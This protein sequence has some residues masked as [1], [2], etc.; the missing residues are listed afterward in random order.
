MGTYYGSVHTIR[1]TASELPSLEFKYLE[2]G[3]AVSDIRCYYHRKLVAV[4]QGFVISDD[5]ENISATRVGEDYRSNLRVTMLHTQW[6]EFP[7]MHWARVWVNN[8]EAPPDEELPRPVL[9][10]PLPELQVSNGGQAKSFTLI[11]E[12]Y[13]PQSG[14][15]PPDCWS[16]G[17]YEAVVTAGPEPGLHEVA[18]G[19]VREVL[20]PQTPGACDF[21]VDPIVPEQWGTLIFSYPV[22]EFWGVELTIEQ[23]Q[24]SPAPVTPD[25]RLEEPLAVSYRLEPAEYRAETVE[26]DLFENGFWLASARGD[27]RSDTGIAHFG[28][29]LPMRLQSTYEAQVVINRGS[30]AEVRSDKIQV[31]VLQGII[32][33]LDASESYRGVD[34]TQGVFVSQE[35]DLLN[36]TSC[37]TGT[38]FIF[39]LAREARVTLTF[40][41]ID[42]LEPDGSTVR[43]RE[44]TLIDEELY[45][46]GEHHYLILPQDLPAGDYEFELRAVGTLDEQEEVLAGIGRSQYRVRNSLPVG[47]ALT[48]G[49]DLFDGHLSV[50]REDLAFPGRRPSLSLTRTYTSQHSDEP[51]VLGVGWIHSYHSRLIVT[52][53]G[54]VI[55]IGGDGSGMRFVDDGDG[56]LMPLKGYHGTLIANHED[57]TYDFYTKAGIR[58]HY[59]HTRNENEWYLDYIADPNGNLITLSYEG[60]YDEYRVEVVRDSAGRSLKFEYEERDFTFWSGKVLIQVQGPYGTSVSY[61]YDDFG[62]LIR[63]TREALRSERYGYLVP[64]DGELRDRHLLRWVEDEVTGASTNYTW[65]W[66]AIGLQ[67]DIEVDASYVASLTRSDSGTTS[68]AYDLS[69][70]SSRAPAELVTQ[71]KDSRN[72]ISVY[73]LNQYGSPLRIVDAEDNAT[74][75]EWAE[76]DVVMT[77][78]VDANGVRTEFTYDEHG[79]LVTESVTVTDMDGQEVTYLTQNTYASPSSFVPR[80]IKNRISERTD[81]NGHTTYFEYDERGNL[82]EERIEVGNV[83][84]A[85]LATLTLR[86]T[87]NDAGDRLSTED[88]RGNMTFFRYDVYG[89]VS[90]VTDARGGVTKTQWDVRSLPIRRTDALGRETVLEYDTLGR[91][92]RRFLPEVDGEGTVDEQILYDD[93]HLRRTEIDGEGRSTVSEFDLEGRVVKVTNAKGGT[94]VFDYDTEGNKILESTRFDS[95]TPRHDTTF[96]YDDACRLERRLEPLGRETSYVYDGV[97]NVLSETVV[98]SGDGS[99]EPR[100]TEFSYDALNR[101][102]EVRRWL[103]PAWVTSR[104]KYD[105]EGNKVLE[106]DPLGR[107]THHRYDALNRLLE[108]V[109]PEWTPGSPHTTQ[110]VYD[111][112]GNLVQSTLLNAPVNQVRT[113]RYDALNRLVTETDALGNTRS[114]EYDAV[115]NPVKE[116]DARLNTRSLAYDARN[117]LVT[118]HRPSDPGERSVAQGHD[119]LR[120]RQGGQPHRRALAQ[121][122]RRGAQLRRPEPIDRNRR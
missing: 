68:F 78:R 31:P 51:G 12:G 93:A 61:Q 23:L 29:G 103:A 121:R 21:T 122:Q 59:V 2:E 14:E 15:P 87:Y 63:A 11:P 44:E 48:H 30:P 45:G 96:E 102:I 74:A 13:D 90:E 32:R 55:I 83:E 73:T 50:V 81:R 101:A 10:T 65:D 7:D 79:N 75:M 22:G 85:T 118:K 115:G 111:G 35:V 108:T 34:G 95:E 104:V 97:G 41:K 84:D 77:A 64:P 39:D 62:N 5:G 69:G 89:N 112:N 25:H 67:G 18:V 54:E 57:N 17:H 110:N 80:H 56:G 49:V 1:V 60:D 88:R 19:R 33:R 36:N 46:E 26:V 16:P 113:R 91:L 76:N 116:I 47:H 106:I 8:R 105:G 82:I 107:E 38:D 86:H 24:P 119:H 53:C 92:I 9:I 117:R 58:Y 40:W 37:G 120:L 43:G 20:R 52:P 3:D 4:S 94:K 70:L 99:F 66:G 6:E 27:S 42:E 114:L 109:G 72:K 100:V 71:I 98:D 28:R